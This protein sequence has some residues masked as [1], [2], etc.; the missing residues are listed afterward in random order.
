VTDGGRK[1]ALVTGASRG[2]GEETAVALAR[3][4]FD[5]ALAARST[6]ALESTAAR[7]T[8][9]GARTLVIPTDVTQE[10]QVRN[11]VGKTSADLGRLDVL[12]NSAG[13]AGF[14]APLTQT[15]PE[16]FEKVLRLNFTHVFWA[17]Q[18]AGR[19]MAG[20]GGGCVVSVTSVAGLA[21]SPGLAGYGAGKAAL[22][23]LTQT[24]AAEWGHAGVRVN[25]VAPG[26]V[27]TELSRYLW[28]NPETERALVARAALGR[29]GEPTEVAEVVAFIASDRA[30]Y[31]TG[32]T[33]VVDGGLSTA[34]L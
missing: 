30:S 13:G 24:A 23:S 7:C 4:G 33:I 10:A 2:I 14:R 20:Q 19:V 17:L 9:Q 18:E 29:W 32:Q 31:L 15:R 6:D 3:D 8:E 22:V 11:L 28:E 5:V 26:W 16:G 21:A 12:V 25:A 1:V 34:A 27:K